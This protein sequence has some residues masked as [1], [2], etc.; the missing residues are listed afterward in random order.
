VR[1]LIDGRRRAN[2][3]HAHGV[4]RE[5]LQVRERAGL[6]ERAYQPTP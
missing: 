5:G 2:A 4:T 6:P 1:Q 3:R